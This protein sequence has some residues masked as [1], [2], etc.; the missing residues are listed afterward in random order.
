MAPWHPPWTRHCHGTIEKIRTDGGGEYLS[1]HFENLCKQ[2]DIQHQYSV[3]YKPHMNG[4]AERSHYTLQMKARCMINATDLGHK[5]WPYAY[6]YAA[7]M[8][9]RSYVN[10]INATPYSLIYKKKP[11]IS[12]LHRFAD[13]ML[14]KKDK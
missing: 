5:V 12:K 6:M 2:Y 4:T 1:T 8:Y 11:N 9:N 10:R 14:A 3:P 13:A 7:Y